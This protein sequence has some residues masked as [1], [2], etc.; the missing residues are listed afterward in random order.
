MNKNNKSPITIVAK[1]TPA[2]KKPSVYPE[3]FA[4]MMAGREKHPLGDL[5]GIK[6]LVSI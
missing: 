1:N 3:P 6:N 4:S 5:F 2:R